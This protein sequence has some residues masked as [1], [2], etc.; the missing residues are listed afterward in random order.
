M[1]RSNSGKSAVLRALHALV[2]NSFVPAYV[3]QGSKTS[4]M[5]ATFDDGVVESKRGGESTYALTRGDEV[6]IFTKA[7]R[8][9][10]DLVADFL[11]MPLLADNSLNFTNQFELPFLVSGKSSAASAVVGTITNAVTTQA[12]AQETNRLRLN[13]LNRIGVREAD[14]EELEMSLTQFDYLTGL[15]ETQTEVHVLGTQLGERVVRSENLCTLLEKMDS[16]AQSVCP[17]PMVPEVDET[18]F[19]RLDSL[20]SDLETVGR[21]FE[22]AENISFVD[23]VDPP[24]VEDELGELSRL[25]GNLTAVMEAATNATQCKQAARATQEAV[26]QAHQVVLSCEEE[27]KNQPVCE[28]CGQPLLEGHEK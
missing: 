9:V 2:Y 11:A 19:D 16:A 15:L 28:A 18:V 1:G 27:I 12:L 24:D 22:R 13:T 5:S 10:P 20:V 8:A 21:L 25:E 6:E 3:R 4:T 23:V 26:D 14:L 17:V 7:G